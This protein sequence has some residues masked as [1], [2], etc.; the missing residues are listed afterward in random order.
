MAIRVT[1]SMMTR[2]FLIN[3][4]AGMKRMDTLQERL[5]SG[6][7]I[8]RLSDDPL[9]LQ[10]LLRIDS[11]QNE[12]EQYM[13]NLDYMLGVHAATESALN[14]IIDTLSS[15][16][17]LCVRALNDTITADERKVITAEVASMLEHLIDVGNAEFSGAFVFAGT[18]F[19][20]RPFRV[21]SR[22][23]Y[24]VPEYEVSENLNAEPRF[25]E[26]GNDVIFKFNRNA[27]DVFGEDVEDP[28]G[29]N[30]FA[31]MRRLVMAL[32][33]DVWEDINNAFDELSGH[34]YRINNLRS[35]YGTLELRMRA[36]HTRHF[37]SLATL[38]SHRNS[39][40]D[41]DMAET[42]MYLKTQETVYRTALETGARLL[43]PSLVDY[44]R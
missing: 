44:L 20:N 16:R 3:L 1:Q 28:D 33:E 4:N 5:Y 27:F 14:T 21:V 41:T 19:I 23:E 29:D 11:T 38:V 24:G 8:N 40:E 34:F 31:V 17:T 26:I 6:K 36:A 43:P 22:D 35:E 37:N 30:V 7:Q 25:M 2:G 18:D 9:N 13:H 15:M 32:H 39:V 10:T 12:T 42:I